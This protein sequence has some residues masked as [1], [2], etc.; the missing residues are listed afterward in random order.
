MYQQCFMS[1]IKSKRK[2]ERYFKTAKVYGD[3]SNTTVGYLLF[4]DLYNVPQVHCE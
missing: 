1:K 3:Q 2:L 4:T